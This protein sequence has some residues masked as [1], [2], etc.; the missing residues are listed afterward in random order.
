[1]DAAFEL[2][3]QG[4]VDHAMTFE[5]ALSPEGL[6][7]DMNS[8]MGF[9]AGPGAGVSGMQIGLVDDFDA[10]GREGFGQLFR[11]DVSDRH[12]LTLVSK[13]R[14]CS[15]VSRKSGNR[16]SGKDDKDMR[17]TNKFTAHPDWDP[18]GMRSMAAMR[19]RQ[20]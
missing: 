18:I 3:R 16:F 4:F 9:A 15:R 14:A 20:C 12:G 13:T 11:D 1:M 8:E 6:R 7:H 19:D 5:P 2:T 17:K 10:F